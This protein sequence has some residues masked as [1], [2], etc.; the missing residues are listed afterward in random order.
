MNTPPPN[1]A[2]TVNV[3][4]MAV[5][6]GLSSLSVQGTVL[7]NTVLTPS[8]SNFSV[9]VGGVSLK[10]STLDSQAGSAAST[11]AATAAASAADEAANTFGTDSVAEQIEYGF[12]A[13]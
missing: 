12:A 4:D 3:T 9:T 13:T 1:N 8:G 11:A 5:S 7:S 6:G 2:L 10:Q